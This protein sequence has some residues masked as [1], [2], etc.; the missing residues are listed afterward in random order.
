MTDGT[1]LR[2]IIMNG[3]TNAVK[4]SSASATG[5]VVSVATT[6]DGMITFSITDDGRGLPPGVTSAALFQDFN[7]IVSSPGTAAASPGSEKR[8]VVQST[9]L[10]LPICNR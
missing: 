3:L 4:Y 8:R 7:A 5:I 2:Q 10:G 1:R 9:G 6:A